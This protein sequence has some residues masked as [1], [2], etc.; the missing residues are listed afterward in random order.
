[1]SEL[2]NDAIDPEA[3]QKILE[4]DERYAQKEEKPMRVLVVDSN[5]LGMGLH[6]VLLEAIANHRINVPT[7][8]EAQLKIREPKLPAI[9][10]LR[11]VDMRHAVLERTHK[12]VP[13]YQ[14]KQS[15]Y[16]RPGHGRR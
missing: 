3:L 16:R 13:F 4:V 12:H 2:T 14:Q 8:H 11:E 5:G 7:V 9:K 10:M 1:M 6:R 15:K